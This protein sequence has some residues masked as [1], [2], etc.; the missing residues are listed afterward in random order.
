MSSLQTLP[1]YSM[2]AAPTELSG[3]VWAGRKPY[4]SARVVGISKTGLPG[5][6]VGRTCR[7]FPI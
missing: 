2:P 1:W 7:V 3:A 4:S 5:R 6:S